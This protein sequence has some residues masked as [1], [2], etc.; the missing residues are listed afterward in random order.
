MALGLLS[1][2]GFVNNFVI[3]AK[4]RLKWDAGGPLAVL[5]FGSGDPAPVSS[6]YPLAYQTG[7]DS[8]LMVIYGSGTNTCRLTRKPVG[9]SAPTG[10]TFTVPDSLLRSWRVH[11]LVYSVNG[12]NDTLRFW[13]DN[14]TVSAKYRGSVSYTENSKRVLMA[15]GE[16]E[17]RTRR[18]F[19]SQILIDWLLV[20]KYQH[21]E[22]SIT[23]GDMQYLPPRLTAV[24][25]DGGYIQLRWTSTRAPLYKVWAATSVTGAYSL[26]LSTADTTAAVARADTAA[27]HCFYYVS[28]ASE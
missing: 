8:G 23:L 15:A 12:G 21:P 9:T 4:Q 22:P 16:G 25:R 5:S 19:G 11:H 13:I 24:A 14:S 18:P 20:R 7:T 27:I 17:S 28:S 3:E 6:F 26:L 2:T 1:D 10:T